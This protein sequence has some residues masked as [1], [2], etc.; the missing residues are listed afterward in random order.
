[1]Y[2]VDTNGSTIATKLKLKCTIRRPKLP[3]K[4]HA[5]TSWTAHPVKPWFFKV[6][7]SG[8]SSWPNLNMIWI[9]LRYLLWQIVTA[10]I[11]S[12]SLHGADYP[13]YRWLESTY[14][15]INLSMSILSVLPFDRLCC[16]F[17]GLD[18]FH[19]VL[20]CRCLGVEEYK[21]VFPIETSMPQN[22]TY[23]Y[24][25]VPA[26]MKRIYSHYS[27]PETLLFVKL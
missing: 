10:L 7:Y 22:T 14:M 18:G 13:T 25:L 27:W 12:G 24:I 21:K 6:G 19:I 5:C 2:V 26:K 8:D 16:S 23:I 1:M 15:P 20:G 3:T 11:G 4:P 9:N 17:V